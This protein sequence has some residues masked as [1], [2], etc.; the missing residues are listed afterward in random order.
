[1]ERR[2][3]TTQNVEGK[4]EKIHVKSKVERRMERKKYGK[5]GTKKV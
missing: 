5:K 3:G 4:K 1:M 2:K